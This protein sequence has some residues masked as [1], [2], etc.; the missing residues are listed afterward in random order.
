MS[1]RRR[2]RKPRTCY[3]C[4]SEET[5]KE[6]VPPK[7]FFPTHREVSG[8][9]SFRQNLI[10][11]PSCNEHNSE[12]SGD[13]QFLLSIITS[14]I[15]NNPI[16][17]RIFSTRV[18]RTLRR[19][20][21]LAPN[22][23]KGLMPVLFGRVQTGMFFLDRP[24]FDKTLINIARGVYF[25]HYSKK[26]LTQGH[27]LTSSMHDVTSERRDE[28][29]KNL[30]QWRLISERAF[31]N[32]P[33]YGENPIVFYYK[34]VEDDEKGRVVCRLV[35]YEGVVVDVLFEAT[36]P[37]LSVMPNPSPGANAGSGRK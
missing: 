31:Q 21:H 35:F 9:I 32:L 22:F 1:K 33:S 8:K 10:T 16:A 13:D 24:R 7:C 23:F 30:H 14:H 19:K 36:E 28:V 6:H 5:S 34:V 17:Q 18:M 25:N 37:E 12:K 20:P 11:V 4:H 26:I 3:M 15:E 29:N 2:P 27:L